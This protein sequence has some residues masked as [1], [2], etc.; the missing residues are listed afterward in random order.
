[1]GG[2][3]PA[4]MDRGRG[5][6][7]MSLLRG[8]RRAGL[9]LLGRPRR[10]P[11]QRER[12]RFRRYCSTVPGFVADPV[13][14]M[15][16]AND[17]TTGDP[18]AA[19]LLAEPRWRGLLIEPVPHCF[20]RLRAT[21]GDPR[22]FSLERIAVGAHP[23]QARFYHVD[24]TARESMPDLPFWVDQLGSFDRGHIV[25]HLDGALAPFIVECEVDVRPLAEVLARHGIQDV[26]LLHIDAEG[27]DLEVLRTLDFAAHVPVAILVEHS[28]LPDSD[29]RA[30]LHLL[31]SRG[32]S[33]RDCGNDYFAL[34]R[35]AYRR[36]RRTGRNRL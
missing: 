15:V 12:E 36:M 2:A 22:R 16:G 4:R 34:H 28:H 20:E 7:D 10:G 19:I 17:G 29:K 33:V 11:Y 32:Y 1:M 25:K 30:L 26:H 5:P 23:G 14:V 9:T 27:H 35:K 18:C 8:I 21:F 3:D 13:F 6:V 31:R 24:P